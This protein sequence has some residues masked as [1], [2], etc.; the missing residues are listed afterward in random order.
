MHMVRDMDLSGN[1][2]GR[3]C[4]SEFANAWAWEE[5]ELKRDVLGLG[6]DV[7]QTLTKVETHMAELEQ[8]QPALI[9]YWSAELEREQRRREEAERDG[10]RW[11]QELQGARSRAIG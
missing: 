11:R 10:E 8:E 4:Y 1:G 3:V 2:D 9:Q 7:V 5:Q 6:P